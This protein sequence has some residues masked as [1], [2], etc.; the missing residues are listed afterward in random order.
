[1]NA[2]YNLD[3]LQAVVSVTSMVGDAATVSKP[4]IATTS[5]Y[6]PTGH[7][8][9]TTSNTSYAGVSFAADG[10]ISGGSLIHELSVPGGN[11]LSTT[12]VGFG[13]NGKPQ[14]AEVN[15]HNNS[16]NGDFKKIQMDMTAATWNNSFA[17]SAGTV[18]LTTL[19]AV[20]GQKLHDGAIQINNETVASATFTHYAKDG[21]GSVTGSSLVD[22]SGAKFLGH[23]IV[24]GQYTVQLHSPDNILKSTSNISVSPLGRV[25]S[26][27]TTNL[28]AAAAGAVSTKVKVDFSKVIFNARNEFHSGEIGYTATDNNGAVL[29]QT[30]VAYNNANPSLSTI[31][32]FKDANLQNKIVVD[33]AASLFNNDRKVVNS[34]K[35]VDTYTGDGK[36]LTSA[37]VAYDALGNKVTGSAAAG[38]TTA[39][40]PPPPPIPPPV[41]STFKLAVPPGAPGTTQKNDRITRADGTLQQLR[42]TTLMGDKPVTAQITLFAA[43]GVTIVKTYTLDLSSLAYDP[44]ARTVI[45]TLNMQSHTGGNVLNSESSIQY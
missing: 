24:G 40:P 18:K 31:S 21:S 26:I 10:T 45:G 12:S 42:V 2:T 44:T 11:K 15:V 16:G 37:V 19:D 25:Q 4:R 8:V 33:Y 22:Y 34:T 5:H 3:H 7:E 27:E 23:N 13:T 29:S 35:K 9:A 32:V 1:M 36:L 6:D 28:S 20:T 30:A 43:D 38:I 39:A 17:I 41:T 14:M